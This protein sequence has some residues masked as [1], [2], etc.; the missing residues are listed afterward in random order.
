MSTESKST[1][2]KVKKI[3]V[4]VKDDEKKL[5]VTPAKP[6]PVKPAKP[7]PVAPKPTA[8]KPAK[9][10]PA[11]EP[12]DEKQI[13][14]TLPALPAEP[15]LS[16]L[17]T[18]HVID[19]FDEL[20]L[21]MNEIDNNPD[22]SVINFTIDNC[23]IEEPVIVREIK[24][25]SDMCDC[26]GRLL[27]NDDVL[28][29]QKCG[30]EVEKNSIITDDNYSATA[31]TECNVNSNG[32]MSMKIIGK[33]SYGLQK[34]MLKTCADYSQYRKLTT[35]KE[36]I[37]WNSNSKKQHIPKNVM[38]EANNMFAKIKD[39]KKVYRKDGKKGVIG[40]C[41][42]YAC[43]NNGIS[44]TPSEIAQFSGIE[45]KFHSRGD[46]ELRALSEMGIIDLPAKINPI[47]DYIDRYLQIL[48]IDTKYKSF[49]TDM[50]KRA[51]E[52]KIHIL[53]DSKSNTKA[54]AVIYILVERV[55]SL[56]AIITDETIS[57]VCNISKTTFI[58]YY[59]IICEYYRKFKKVFKRHGIPMPNSWREDE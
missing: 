31:N 38:I 2:R 55:A 32:F 13:K 15:T 44:K 9:P 58:R 11:P 34:S 52:K 56:R 47:N 30:V 17:P 7:K 10:K 43:Y 48:K 57:S 26:G 16:A 27:L 20:E 51:N 39:H 45:D 33:K 4:P 18:N 46:R 1:E 23:I 50:I 6:T 37:S 25:G 14:T 41:I 29:C 59:K 49:L 36:I 5:H 8:V 53:Y 42:Y 19:E 22:L 35:L 24:K 12:I 54:C 28:L 3:K 40:S 21:L